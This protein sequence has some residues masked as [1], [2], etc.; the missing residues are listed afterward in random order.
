VTAEAL[1]IEAPEIIVRPMMILD[2]AADDF[3]SDCRRRGWSTRSIQ[4]YRRTY[5]EFA[6]RLPFDYDV[7][8]ITTDDVRRYLATKSRLA[9][10]TIA[11]HEAH[12]AGL[13]KWLLFEGKIKRDP[14]ATLARTKRRRAEDLEV[15]TIS[16]EDVQRLLL[17]AEGWSERIALAILVYLGPRRHAVALLRLSDYDRARGRIKF[18][19]KGGRIIWKP[20]PDELD[21]LL[22]AAIAAGVYKDTDYLVPPGGPLSRSGDRDDRVIWRLVKQAAQRAGVDCHVHALRAAFAVFYDEKNPGDTLALRDLMGHSS[23]QTTELYLRR[24]NKEAGMER[25]RALSWGVSL[26]EHENGK[27]VRLVD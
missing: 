10:G 6:D 24:R 8:K 15:K 20:I 14:M 25:V 26:G 23:V 2:R 9:E 16:S 1:N 17:H 4:T 27:V 12:L 3:L 11:G 18:R 22:E 5:N 13:F 21:A 7:S 19:E